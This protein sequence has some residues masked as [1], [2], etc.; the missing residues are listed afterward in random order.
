MRVEITNVEEDFG[1]LHINL[2]KDDDAT[3]QASGA[4]CTIS[5]PLYNYQAAEIVD[6]LK[7]IKESESL[8]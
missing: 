1:T 6:A 5:I 3:I 4:G 8:V 7:P 2:D